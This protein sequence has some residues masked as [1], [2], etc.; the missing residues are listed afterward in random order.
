[1][2]WLPKIPKTKWPSNLE[3]SNRTDR[4]KITK[5]T[6]Q[7]EKKNKDM[8]DSIVKKFY[9]QEIM[10]RYTYLLNLHGIFTKKISID[11]KK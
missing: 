10:G 5:L 9:T 3:L 8:G 7:V 2:C 6:F 4:T 11:S 1:M